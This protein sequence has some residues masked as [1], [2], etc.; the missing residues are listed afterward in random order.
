MKKVNP[1]TLETE[2]LGEAFVN[3]ADYSECSRKSLFSVDLKKSSFPEA[4]IEF[5]VTATQDSNLS[6]KRTNTLLEDKRPSG[7][8]INIAR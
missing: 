3:L 1:T 2:F 5:Y 7:D 6:R 4:R 8:N